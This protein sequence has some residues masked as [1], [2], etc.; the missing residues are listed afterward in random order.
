MNKTKIMSF[1]IGDIDK[2]KKIP[3]EMRKLKED[4]STRN[5]WKLMGIFLIFFLVFYTAMAGLRS[6]QERAQYCE[7]IEDI[8]TGSGY[9]YIED[10]K[11]PENNKSYRYYLDFWE[12]NKKPMNMGIKCEFDIKRYFREITN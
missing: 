4:L 7:V 6:V 2:W 11:K 5:R 1:F 3:Q 9:M 12:E 8:T 10:I